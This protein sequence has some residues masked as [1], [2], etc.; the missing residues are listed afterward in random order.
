MTR[1][2]LFFAFAFL[3]RVPGVYVVF[4]IGL[5]GFSNSTSC[6]LGLLDE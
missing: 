5:P 4:F 6:L 3:V 2:Q 1:Q